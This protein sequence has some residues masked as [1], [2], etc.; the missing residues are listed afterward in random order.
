MYYYTNFPPIDPLQWMGAVRMRVQTADKNI[1]IIHSQSVNVLWSEKLGR[2]CRK[3]WERT[4]SLEDVLLRTEDSNFR[5]KQQF[6]AKNALMMDLV[7]TK[8]FTSQD[9]SWWTGVVWIIIM[10]LSAVWTHSDGT[11]SLQRIYWW[12]SDVIIYYSKFV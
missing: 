11:H 4:F 3:S 5:W 10:F 7:L 1:T 6:E 9:V 2:E 12:A 8:H